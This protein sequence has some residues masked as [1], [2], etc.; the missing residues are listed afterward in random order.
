MDALGDYSSDDDDNIG[1][2]DSAAQTDEG[3]SSSSGGGHHQDLMEVTTPSSKR[4][5]ST[6]ERESH[7]SNQPFV[8]PP[9]PPIQPQQPHTTASMQPSDLLRL[10]EGPGLGP[11]AITARAT[12]G[13]ASGSATVLGE[14]RKVDA[15]A[16]PAGVPKPVTSFRPP[17]LSRPNVNTEDIGAWTTAK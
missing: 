13:G 5:S 12:S 8:G 2:D 9:R 3:N 6:G 14:K 11:S 15:I 17:Q 16:K 4:E 7:Q 10:L 1:G